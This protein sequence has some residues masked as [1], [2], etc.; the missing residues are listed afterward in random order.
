MTVFEYIFLLTNVL[1]FDNK[2]LY[3][4]S[5]RHR[6]TAVDMSSICAFKAERNGERTENN[7]R[8]D[9]KNKRN[10][11]SLSSSGMWRH[12]ALIR[13]DVSEKHHL[14]LLGEKNQRIRSLHQLLVTANVVPSVLIP[15]SLMMEATHSPKSMF[16]PDLRCVTFQNTAF[17]IVTAVE[18]SNLTKKYLMNYFPADELTLSETVH[19]RCFTF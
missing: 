13:T 10:I 2:A 15:F 6:M 17:L 7:M 18:T 4:D 9:K 5:L 11:W 19:T 8:K 14:H 1:P 3:T 16:L 12:G